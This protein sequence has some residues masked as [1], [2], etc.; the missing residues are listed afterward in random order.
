MADAGTRCV[1][2]VLQMTYG[3]LVEVAD[4]GH[5]VDRVDSLDVRLLNCTMPPR[6]YSYE[7]AVKMSASRR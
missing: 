7:G 6:C 3:D 1:V 5:L 4:D 2:A